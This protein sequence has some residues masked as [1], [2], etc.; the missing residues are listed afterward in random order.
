[1]F[2]NPE[3]WEGF[4]SILYDK[5]H[6]RDVYVPYNSKGGPVLKNR[7]YKGYYEAPCF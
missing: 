6:L 3:R 5:H 4:S 2:F 7:L 1:M